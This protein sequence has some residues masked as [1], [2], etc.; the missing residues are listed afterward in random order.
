MGNSAFRHLA[1]RQDEASGKGRDLLTLRIHGS[2]SQDQSE[3]YEILI[4]I[5]FGFDFS[6]FGRCTVSIPA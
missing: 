2:L 5:D 4:S 3:T 1:G 6:D